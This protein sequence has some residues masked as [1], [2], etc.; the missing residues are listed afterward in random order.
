M[1]VS[2]VLFCSFKYILLLRTLRLVQLILWRWWHRFLYWLTRHLHQQDGWQQSKKQK[3][4][5]REIPPRP[6]PDY[7]CNTI[8][9]SEWHK[10]LW[11]SLSCIPMTTLSFR[12]KCYILHCLFSSRFTHP[13]D[14][15]RKLFLPSIIWY[16]RDMPFVFEKIFLFD[17]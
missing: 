12:S 15:E 5:Y 13:S 7:I 10:W 14:K 2:H 9:S 17:C 3:E 1:P 4:R 8:N 6:Q 16:L 11:G